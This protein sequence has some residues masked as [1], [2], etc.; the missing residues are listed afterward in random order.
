MA[1]KPPKTISKREINKRAKKLLAE[2]G[3]QMPS[4]QE[5]LDAMRQ[6]GSF[7]AS[8]PWY[9]RFMPRVLWNRFVLMGKLV[10]SYKRGE[11]RR[12]PWKVIASLVF[13]IGYVVCPVDLIPDYIPVVGFVDDTVVVGLV[14]NQ[15][16]DE[17]RRFVIF[18]GLDLADYRLA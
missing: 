12:V 6:A 4:N 17:L 2:A 9:T 11:Y 16:A 3:R 18:K 8:P 10:A 15:V 5:L 14:F 13:A 1:K 7:E